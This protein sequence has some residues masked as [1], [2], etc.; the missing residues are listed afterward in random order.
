VQGELLEEAAS[1]LQ[2]RLNVEQPGNGLVTIA[3]FTAALI[4]CSPPARRIETDKIRS[5]YFVEGGW[6]ELAR[7]TFASGVVESISIHSPNL[8]V[9]QAVLR[10][11]DPGPEIVAMNYVAA[12]RKWG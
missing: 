3:Q 1:L 2:L 6:I 5:Q 10:Y 11:L 9:V 12:C 7:V 4:G 8:A